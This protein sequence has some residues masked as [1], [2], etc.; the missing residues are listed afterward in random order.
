MDFLNAN[1]KMA[2]LL[3]TV[4]R[5]A[6]L[7]KDCAAILPGIFTACEVL[8]FESDKLVLSV[9]S[10]ALAA[11]L[12]QTL[13]RLRESLLKRG[14]QVSAIRLKVQVDQVVVKAKPEKRA[15][16]SGSALVALEELEKSLE[17]K[18]YNDPLRAALQAMVQRHRARQQE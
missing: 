3:P 13:P 6:A 14:W 7:Q 1:D 10:A 4:A 15:T 12:K 5:M 11:K 18:P 16:L 17:A 2:S 8:Q 9:P